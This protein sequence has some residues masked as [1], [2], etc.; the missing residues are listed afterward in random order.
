MADYAAVLTTKTWTGG[1]STANPNSGNWSTSGNWS[2]TGAPLTNDDVV[3]GGNSGGGY[4]VTLDVS[5]ATLD[6]LT[7]NFTGN[8]ATLVIGNKTLNVNGNGIGA[9]DAV[10]LTGPTPLPLPAARSTRAPSLLTE[11]APA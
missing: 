9:T 2:P 8:T 3:I 10:I 4:T 5:P 6:S 1:G 11:P 7:M